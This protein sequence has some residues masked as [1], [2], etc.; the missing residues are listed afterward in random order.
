MSKQVDMVNGEVVDISDNPFAGMQLRCTR[1]HGGESESPGGALTDPTRKADDP[2]TVVRC[3]ECGKRHSTD[4]LEL[5][6]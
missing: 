3:A 6:E 2:K 5:A 1:C 4:S